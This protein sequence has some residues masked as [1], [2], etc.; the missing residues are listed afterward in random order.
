MY[1]K[2]WR[3][4][5]VVIC[6]SKLYGFLPFSLLLPMLK[7]PRR[8]R[9][10]IMRNNFLTAYDHSSFLNL[11]IGNYLRFTSVFVFMR[12]WFVSR[13]TSF[14]IILNECHFNL[15]LLQSSFC[16]FDYSQLDLR[17]D[18]R[19]FVSSYTWPTVPSVGASLIPQRTGDLLYKYLTI[20]KFC[21]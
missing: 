19:S 10:V 9:N 1:K 7:L 4:C 18:S 8:L 15:M 17:M 12:F 6:Q 16:L 2:A 3:T 11:T 21:K 20:N 13:V 5:K 14:P